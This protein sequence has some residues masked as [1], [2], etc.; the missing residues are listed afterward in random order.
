MLTEPVC[1]FKR[2]NYLAVLKRPTIYAFGYWWQIR[3]VVQVAE[4]VLTHQVGNLIFFFSLAALNLRPRMKFGLPG[5]LSWN[6]I[7]DFKCIAPKD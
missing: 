2:N 3:R 7:W 5:A 1:H 4:F 6:E